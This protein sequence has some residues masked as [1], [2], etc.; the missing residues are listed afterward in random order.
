M[1]SLFEKILWKSGIKGPI[2]SPPQR[3]H[4]SGPYADLH[5]ARR[6][7]PACIKLL[8]QDFQITDGFSFYWMYQEIFID[9]VYNIKS[10]RDAPIII[11]CGGSYGVSA[12]YFKSRFPDCK[13]KIVEADPTIFS[14]LA[15]NIR[16][17]GHSDMTLL[18]NAVASESG[19]SLPFYALGADMGR[20]HPGTVAAPCVSIP[21][22]CL[23]DLIEEKTDFLKIDIE[24]AETDVL[25]SCKK[26]DLVDQ[27]FIEYHSFADQEQTLDELLAIIRAHGFRY[28]IQTILTPP[29]PFL[30]QTTNHGMDLQ[31]GISAT[32][33]HG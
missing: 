16:N 22:I 14:I 2:P 10:E 20:L 32:R 6:H 12:L 11:D 4:P 17:S 3:A 29:K 18:N 25:R 24:G 15:S 33:Y 28:Y 5:D 21:T 31:L 30:E 13:I 19:Q 7:Q 8:D 1:R 27:L 23:D 9:G 26:L